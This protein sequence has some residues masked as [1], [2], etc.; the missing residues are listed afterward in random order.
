MT[1][2]FYRRKIK[3]CIIFGRKINGIMHTPIIRVIICFGRI[4]IDIIVLWK[5]KKD[6]YYCWKENK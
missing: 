5:K 3:I 6:V 1:S 2:L 4:I